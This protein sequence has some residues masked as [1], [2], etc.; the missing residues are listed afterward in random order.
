MIVYSKKK[1]VN[2][3]GL[4][5]SVDFCIDLMEIHRDF[6]SS[7]FFIV[8]GWEKKNLNRGIVS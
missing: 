3:Q 4:H 7:Q 2:N 5:V 8:P 6:I 1:A